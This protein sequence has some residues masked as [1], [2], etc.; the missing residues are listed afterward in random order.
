M[1]IYWVL[2]LWRLAV[3]NF[4]WTVHQIKNNVWLFVILEAKSLKRCL[5]FIEFLKLYLWKLII[6]K[7][8]LKKIFIYFVKLS[9]TFFNF[10]IHHI[11]IN[12]SLKGSEFRLNKS[13]IINII[14]RFSVLVL[15]L[16]FIKFFIKPLLNF[17]FLI[18]E[19]TFKIT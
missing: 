1:R 17:V 14:M 18:F 10:S 5:V 2:I 19:L 15:I 11:F 12:L 4:I 8:L 6:I 16:S 9:L 13:I 3:F 7:S